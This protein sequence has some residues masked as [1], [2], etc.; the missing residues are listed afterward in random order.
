MARPTKLT[1]LVQAAFCESRKIGASIAGAAGQA[2]ISTD[3]A[4]DWL[5]RGAV[6][7]SGI[8]REFYLADQIARSAFEVE[9]LRIIQEAAGP[10]HVLRRRS[11]HGPKGSFEEETEETL[12]DWNAA[13][14][15]LARRMPD[16]YGP[17]QEMRHTGPEGGP[18]LFRE[19]VVEMPPL[20]DEPDADDFDPAAEEPE[21][22]GDD[23]EGG[24][25][26]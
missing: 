12:I 21:S 16:E 22:A 15:L 14:W 2:G 9:A 18:L 7:L 25:I 5:K 23:G 4:T 17:R 24:Y 11:G 1:P 19:V 3:T 26:A 13:A 10:R 8:F 6:A 20:E